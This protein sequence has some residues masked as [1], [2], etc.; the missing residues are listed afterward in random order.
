DAGRGMSV[1]VR[2]V[3]VGFGCDPYLDRCLGAWEEARAAA[4]VEA[5]T[6]V[7]LP[8]GETA[9]DLARR[10]RVIEVAPGE[11]STPGANRNRGAVGATCDWLLFL[12]GDVE[13]MKSFVA[14]A[15]EA[16]AGQPRVAGFA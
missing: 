10:A 1:P 3:V 13:L 4:G 5:E 9:L 16:V 15:L 12:D 7:V 2:A 11:N 8:A 6:V 14:K